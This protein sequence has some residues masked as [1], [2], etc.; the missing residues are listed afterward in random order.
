MAY[1]FQGSI[2]QLY[3]QFAAS[4]V[5][6]VV[7]GENYYKVMLFVGETEAASYFTVAPAVGS[8]T[9]CNSGNFATTVIGPLLAYLTQFYANNTVSTVY[10]VVYDDTTVTVGTFPAG[11]VTALTT[12]FNAYHDRAYFKMI[13]LHNNIPANSAL[14]TLCHSDVLLSQCWIDAN[15]AQMLVPASVT[16]M[17]GVC[18]LAGSSPVIV[19]HPDA[20]KSGALTQL[21][22]S[23]ATINGTGTPV[24]NSLDY[25]GTA[26]MTGSGASGANLSASDIATLTAINCGFFLTI[27]DGTGRVALKGGKT[28]TGSVAAADWLVQYIDF[29]AAVQTANMLTTLNRFKN[30]ETYQCILTILSNL[31]NSFYSI[32]RISNVIISAPTFSKLPPATGDMITIPN[33]W[34]A[35]YNDNIRR[36][37]VQ[38]TLYITAS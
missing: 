25:L 23:L 4:V 30:N 10:V 28:I 27:G 35:T 16:S 33:A 22:L 18:H 7:P 26:E 37:A 1:D 20:T 11:A 36:V 19:Y 29:V 24:A 15:D 12:Q 31:L 6:S 5:A 3:I 38:G 8:I 14:A 32:G 13:T 17:Y 2:A 9:E 21:G 34:S